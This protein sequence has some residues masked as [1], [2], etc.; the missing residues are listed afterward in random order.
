FFS[1]GDF[2]SVVED[3]EG[4]LYFGSTKGLA[5]VSPDLQK[6]EFITDAQ[7]LSSNR[8]SRLL[9]HGPRLWI[10][11]YGGGL[12]LLDVTTKRVTNYRYDDTDPHSLSSDMSFTLL[13]DKHENLWV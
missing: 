11:T 12:N 8:I 13:L 7:G 9:L 2:W 4:R 1:S 10:A 3:G 5:M 6:V